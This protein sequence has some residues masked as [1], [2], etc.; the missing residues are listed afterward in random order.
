MMPAR[1]QDKLGFQRRMRIQRSAEFRCLKETG[2]RI[3]YGC[4]TANWGETRKH[5]HPRLG[6]ITSKRIGSSVTRNRTRRIIREAFRLHQHEIRNPVS[7]VLVA[8]KS[9]A[10]KSMREVERDMLKL[11]ERAGLLKDSK[12]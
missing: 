3:S 11:F 9:I 2:S 6:V 1:A 10:D 7:I 5:S 12:Q 8:R 4:L